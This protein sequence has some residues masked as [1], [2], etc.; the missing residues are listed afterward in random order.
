[1][2]KDIIADRIL[3][4]IKDGN[5]NFSVFEEG[6]N[7]D[8]QMDYA[9]F[10]VK[11]K[12]E[13]LNSENLDQDIEELFSEEVDI[14]KKKLL[15]VRLSFED[16]VKAFRALEKFAEID[17]NEE[18]HDW[19]V[20]T[21]QQSRILIE[22]ALTDENRIYISSGMGGVGNKL[23]F[24][25][26]FSTLNKTVFNDLQ[27][28]IVEKEINYTL[29]THEGVVEEVIFYDTYVTFTSLIPIDVS[30][31]DVLNKVVD[32]CNVLGNFLS[33]SI[34]VTNVKRLNEEEIDELINKSKNE[35][36]LENPNDLKIEN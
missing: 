22:T 26:I 12:K 3:E 1:M 4:K 24:F 36:A 25:S 21:L 15:L 20:L 30:L 28:T 34:F 7:F 16:D 13:D 23:R 29:P 35:K 14:E 5:S 11:Q 6:T 27:K 10:I 33:E 19:G 32:D 31:K 2:D 17:D 8:L 9:D 18:L